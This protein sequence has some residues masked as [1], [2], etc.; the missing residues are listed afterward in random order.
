MQLKN[1][2]PLVMVMLAASWSIGCKEDLG[3]LRDP[4]KKVEVEYTYAATADSM[5]EATNNTYLTIE[6]TYKQDNLGNEFFNYWWNAHMVHVLVDGYIRS[7]NQTYLTRAKALVEGINTRNNGHFPNE[8]NDDMAWL[9]IACTRAYEQS[10]DEYFLDV[11]RLLWEEILKSWS[12]LYGGGITWKINTPQSK[13][14]VSNAPV[15]ILSM[16]LYQLDGDAKYLQ[17]AKDIYAWQKS[18]L[19]DPVTGLVWDH[20]YTENGQV[21]V[22]KEW[23]FTYNVGTYIGASLELY[24][25]TG[26]SSYL[27]EALKTARS[28]VN[29]SQL[30]TEGLLKDEGQGD[31]GLF[32]GILVRYFT[33]LMLRDDLTESDRQ[34]FTDFFTFNAQTFYTNAIDRPSML[35]SPNWRNQ[36]GDRIDLSTQLSGVMLMEAAALLESQE[37]L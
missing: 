4:D 5:Q 8:F 33:Q 11:S 28:M 6:S 24:N 12:D 34:T 23:I 26:E 21:L 35:C 29:S 20:M 3:A 18:N 32:K 16:R 7:N 14:A 17:W 36:P 30:T 22:K 9:A 31:G 15:A 19:V 13:N 10:N 27:N 25:E 1:K 2:L 37:K